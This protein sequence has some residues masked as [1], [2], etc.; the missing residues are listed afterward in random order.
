MSSLPAVRRAVPE[1]RVAIVGRPRG[2]LAPLRR[3]ISELGVVKDPDVDLGFA[4]WSTSDPNRSLAESWY[5]RSFTTQDPAQAA[6][7]SHVALTHDPDHLL[8]LENLAR[9]SAL[10]AVVIPAAPGFYHRPESIADLVDFVVQRICDHIGVAVDLA[11]PDL[12]DR[13]RGRGVKGPHRWE[14]YWSCLSDCLEVFGTDNAGAHFMVGMGETEREMC[15]AIQ[16]V[17]DMGGGT[18]LFSFYPEGNSLMADH[19]LPA[20]DT[21]QGTL[22]VGR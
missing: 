14:K 20:M 10:G 5:L 19:P 13:F 22:I 9:L 6:V 11:T 8:A 1:A 21:Y 3:L 18:H 12:F 16:R 17:K 2:P 7:Y 15:S 4:A